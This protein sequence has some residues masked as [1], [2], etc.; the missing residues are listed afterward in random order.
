MFSKLEKIIDISE[1][2]LPEGGGSTGLDANKLAGLNEEYNKE[3]VQVDKERRSRRRSIA[4]RGSDETR[5][6]GLKQF[7]EYEDLFSDLT[8]RNWIDTEFDVINIIISYDSK[9][10]IAI[11]HDMYEE[12]QVQGYDLSTYEKK[13]AKIYEGTYIFMN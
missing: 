11:V 7:A 10:A 8:L 12:F 4:S 1:P 2:L 3:N 13:F 6:D 5:I 9:H